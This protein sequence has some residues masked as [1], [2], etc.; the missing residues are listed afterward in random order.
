MDINESKRKLFK[1]NKK[2][3]QALTR[4]IRGV[5]TNYQHQEY[6]DITTVI[7]DPINMGTLWILCLLIR[8][9]L[10]N[11]KIHWMTEITKALKYKYIKCSLVSTEEMNCSLKTFY[12]KSIPGL[13]DTPVEWNQTVEEIIAI[14][15]QLFNIRKDNRPFY[16]S[17]I[18]LI[19]KPD[20]DIDNFQTVSLMNLDIKPSVK[21]K[22]WNINRDIW[23][24][25]KWS[26]ENSTT[27]IYGF[28]SNTHGIFTN[29]DFVINHKS[30]LNILWMIEII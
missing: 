26:K 18:T 4:H 10:R 28:F 1:M 16:E 23:N 11:W 14:L 30:Y 3:D 9:V 5:Q 20:I 15:L 29:I 17:S 6:K 22:K 12:K 2:I 7:L 21:F 8:Q 27:I 25:T 19:L 13:D 24:S